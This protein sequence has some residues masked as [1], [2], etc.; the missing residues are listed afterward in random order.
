MGVIGIRR[1][2]KSEY[3]RRAPLTPRQVGRAI[4]RF[5]ISVQVERAPHRV[6]SEEE[7]AA[8]GAVIVDELA[9]CDLVLG[10]K[11]VPKEK[12][13]GN[14]AYLFFSHTIKAQAYNM[15]M[16]KTMVEK[17]CTLM[18]YE[19]ITDEAG[20]R[21]VFFGYHAGLAGMI[22]SLWMAGRRLEQRGVANPFSRM[23]MSFEYRD[24]AEAVADV[25][26]AGR[27]ISR[28]GFPPEVSPFVVGVT[29][30]GNVARGAHFVLKHLPLREVA[31]CDLADLRGGEASRNVVHVASFSEE[32]L[33][34][35][36]DEEA[37]D[38][39]DYLARPSG[40]RSIFGTYL[41]YIHLLINGIYWEP[42]YPRLVTRELLGVLSA[43]GRLPLIG[44][45]DISC[46]VEG[47]I[48]ITSRTT[49]QWAPLVS[50]DPVSG[51]EDSRGEGPGVAVLAI[52][53]L[54]AEL[55]RD[56][57]EHF[58]NALFGF[59]HHLASL[60]LDKAFDVADYPGELR[61]AT[62]LWR[63]ELTPGFE[64]LREYI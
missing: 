31:P 6:F 35:R 13:R 19:R 8:E 24:L 3:E 11:E 50:Y 30:Y 64:Y 62:I 56:A 36:V 43:Q 53:N 33:V 4:E 1:E 20:R 60:P 55:P 15:P 25:E 42:K 26:L 16:L 29:G 49:T 28:S 7:Y 39:S 38:L 59:L 44:I 45:G 46:D 14:Q 32:H 23:R 37:F 22:D 57:T 17:G 52:D 9:Q 63:G 5:G 21:L 34:Q 18:D 48:E 27:E 2:D 40:Y 61:R 47:S 51:E 12:L 58:G 41:P 54:P 10:V